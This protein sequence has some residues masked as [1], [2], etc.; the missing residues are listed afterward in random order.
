MRVRIQFQ[1]FDSPS[2]NTQ[3]QKIELQGYDTNSFTEKRVQERTADLT[4]AYAELQ[5]QMKE[6]KR[7]E[8]ELLEIAENERRRIGFDLHDDIGASLSYMSILSEVLGR[9]TDG[10]RVDQKQALSEIG[11]TAR[12]LV[13]SMSDVVWAIDPENDRLRDLAQRMRWLGGEV[14]QARK[15][16]FQ[17]QGP[18]EGEDFEVRTDLRREIF[19]IFKEAVNNIIRHSGGTEAHVEFR[20]EGEWLVLKVADNGRAFDP[21]RIHGGHGVRSM[22]E[23]ANR[24]G[25]IL[26]IVSEPRMGTT[27]TLRV[28]RSGALAGWKRILHRG[29]GICLRIS[30]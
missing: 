4:A 1:D 7:L 16:Q 29:T 9:Q 11:A 24:M 20:S 2:K 28:P 6:R 15:I 10:E 17:F 26:R 3:K 23:R 12:E 25:G 19:L 5:S 18:V 14:F 27:L 8:N 13:D 30:L 22:R 21:S